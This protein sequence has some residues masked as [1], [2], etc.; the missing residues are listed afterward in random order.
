M[1]KQVYAWDYLLLQL[2]NGMYKKSLNLRNNARGGTSTTT[3]YALQLSLTIYNKLP[4]IFAV[5]PRAER[6]RY[7]CVDMLISCIYA[8]LLVW[9]WVRVHVQK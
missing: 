7:I 2:K 9:V 8:R 6:D 1:N 3:A 5:R 4:Q